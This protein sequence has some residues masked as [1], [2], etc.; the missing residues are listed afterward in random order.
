MTGALMSPPNALVTFLSPVLWSLD[1]VH[2][3]ADKGVTTDILKNIL[4][5]FDAYTYF[6]KS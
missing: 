2:L 6:I 4:R 3:A 5:Q 1:K